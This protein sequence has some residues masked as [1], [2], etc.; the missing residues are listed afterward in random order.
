MNPSSQFKERLKRFF[1]NPAVGFLGRIASIIGIPPAFYLGAKD[2][3]EL[4]YGVLSG[5]IVLVE[6]ARPGDIKLEYKGRTIDTDVVLMQLAIWNRGQCEH[7]TR[8]CAFPTGNSTE[9]RPRDSKGV[10]WEEESRYYR[11]QYNNIT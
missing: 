1:S 3:P 5:R 4:V 8:E 10:P 9:A 7:Q 11:I 6:S 2:N